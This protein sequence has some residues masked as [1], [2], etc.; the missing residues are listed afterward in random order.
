M[1]D[2]NNF[3]YIIDTILQ[4]VISSQAACRQVAIYF[5]EE[6]AKRNKVTV[7]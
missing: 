6:I 1:E 7:L 5:L 3:N 2:R 4:N